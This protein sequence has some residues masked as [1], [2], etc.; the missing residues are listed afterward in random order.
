MWGFWCILHNMT[1]S[2]NPWDTLGKNIF[3]THNK[4]GEIDPRVADNILLAW[5]PIIKCIKQNFPSPKGVSAL[6]FGCGTGG[7]CNKLKELGFEVTG[8]DSSNEM[9]QTARKNSPRV[10][11][12][13]FGDKSAL[14]SNKSFHIVTS[15][16]TFQF[17]KDIDKTVQATSKI[18]YPHGLFVFA[19]FNPKWVK[20]SLE[21][22]IKFADFNSNVNPKIGW[23][24]FGDIRIPVFI[25][26]AI[27]YNNLLTNNGFVK[28]LEKRPPFTKQFLRIYPNYYP[29]N[30]SEYLILGYKKG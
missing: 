19:V 27:E 16:M 8:I 28:I 7:F 26:D 12:Y 11:R 22:N 14:P 13:I 24:T 30:V 17:I 18:V 1:S 20:E 3:N 2:Q 15:I 5:P 25:R 29:H 9:I 6:D 4:N 21:R 23:K 10:I